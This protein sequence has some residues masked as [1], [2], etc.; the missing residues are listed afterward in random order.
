MGFKKKKKVFHLE[1]KKS[2]LLCSHANIC[3]L[4]HSFLLE[5]PCYFLL[6]SSL[7][8]ATM[9]SLSFRMVINIEKVTQLQTSEQRVFKY[10]GLR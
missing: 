10:F 1:G 4:F 2:I 5:S 9:T 8:K 3:H 7:G 6:S